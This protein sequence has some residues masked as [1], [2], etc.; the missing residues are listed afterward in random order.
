LAARPTPRAVA[1][2]SGFPGHVLRPQPS[3]RPLAEQQVV[4]GNPAVLEIE[5]AVRREPL[6][7]LL[8]EP[9]DAKSR[10]VRRDDEE[11]HGG[12][13]GCVGVGPRRNEIELCHAAVGHIALASVDDVL[14][15]LPA[16]HR[17]EVDPTVVVVALVVRSH[18][19]FGYGD[20]QRCLRILDERGDEAIP[21][22]LC[23]RSA[24]DPSHLLALVH[25]HGEAEITDCK[26]LARKRHRQ[27]VRPRA[28]VLP[29][30]PQRS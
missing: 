10:R 28:A 30:D 11:A 7:A 9:T 19:R 1:A 20:S 24:E 27:D 15:P 2:A 29:R 13:K 25:D 17:S 3:H 16:R 21:L 26:L 5:L 12:G 23:H 6:T 4:G 8:V 18:G 22:R 14:V